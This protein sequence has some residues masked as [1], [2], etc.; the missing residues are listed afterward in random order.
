V[1]RYELDEWDVLGASGEG[2][3]VALQNI[4]TQLETVVANFAK[5]SMDA[6]ARAEYAR[7]M[8]KN[9]D[10]LSVGVVKALDSIDRSLLDA[11]VIARVEAM[12]AE[13]G[14]MHS[15]SEISKEVGASAKRL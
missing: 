1:A 12:R 10:A 4:A 5:L 13:L 14:K 7:G 9:I 11:Q 15:F 3:K 8:W 2:V 6:A